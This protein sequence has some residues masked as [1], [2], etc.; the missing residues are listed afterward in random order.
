MYDKNF[1]NKQSTGCNEYIHFI[2][3]ISDVLKKSYSEK[4]REILFKN[5]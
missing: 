1:W 5:L 2:R 4:F 3:N